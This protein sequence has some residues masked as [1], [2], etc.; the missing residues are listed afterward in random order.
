MLVTLPSKRIMNVLGLISALAIWACG[1]SWAAGHAIIDWLDTQVTSYPSK[2][3]RTAHPDCYPGDMVHIGRTLG[4]G[5]LVITGRVRLI[6][7]KHYDTWYGEATVDVIESLYGHC[8]TNYVVCLSTNTFIPEGNGRY[9]YQSTYDG[10]GWLIPG[11]TVLLALRYE[12]TNPALRGMLCVGE[13]RY[14]RGGPGASEE[15]TYVQYGQ[16]QFNWGAY[17][18]AVDMGGTVDPYNYLTV[19]RA[20]GARLREDAAVLLGREE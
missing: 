20:K 18:A 9:S 12:R 13:V 19:R 14:L 4:P 17:R 8:D 16:P 7:P 1:H 15:V 2:E 5:D 3:F 10:P 11:D 6:T